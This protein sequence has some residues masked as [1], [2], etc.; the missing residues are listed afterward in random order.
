MHLGRRCV[1]PLP[2]EKP[3]AAHHLFGNSFGEVETPPM[4]RVCLLV[5]SFVAALGF[6]AP[7]P[8]Q[9]HESSGFKARRKGVRPEGDTKWLT[10]NGFGGFSFLRKGR[11]ISKTPPRP[12]RS[13]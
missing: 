3:L 11:R 1:D 5:G 8:R 10:A 4:G 2:D 12:Q 13:T 9:I 7:R 6:P